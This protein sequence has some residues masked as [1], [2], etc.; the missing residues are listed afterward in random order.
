[1]DSKEGDSEQFSAADV[2][3]LVGLA[4]NTLQNWMRLYLEEELGAPRR[5]E[6][7]RAYSRR[8]VAVLQRMKQF[9]DQGMKPGPA[10][11]V[12]L[13][14]LMMGVLG[15]DLS[16]TRRLRDYAAGEDVHRM[17]GALASRDSLEERLQHLPLW[18]SI[19]LCAD[20]AARFQT[21]PDALDPLLG[22]DRISYRAVRALSEWLNIHAL[23]V[24][25]LFS[26]PDD[27]WARLSVERDFVGVGDPRDANF[28]KNAE[29]SVALNKLA[30]SDAAIGVLKLAGGG[31][32]DRH[33]HPGTEL[34]FGLSGHVR[35]QLDG[36]VPTEIGEGD[37]AFYRSE[38]LHVVENSSD[39]IPAQA[40]IIRFYDLEGT[41][42]DGT[43]AATALG[44]R[45]PGVNW[46]G[47]VRVLAMAS[48]SR[49]LSVEAAELERRA[50]GLSDSGLRSMLH[51]IADERGIERVIVESFLATPV[52]PC[53]VMPDLGAK[54]RRHRQH[55]F[56]PA[57]ECGLEEGVTYWRAE[58]ALEGSDVQIALIDLEAKS[59]TPVNTHPGSELLI[60]VRG[61]CQVHFAASGDSPASSAPASTGHCLH[62]RSDAPHWVEG[63][64]EGGRL[65]T[66]RFFS[67]R[68][69]LADHVSAA[70]ASSAD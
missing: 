67:E 62:Y 1:M 65:L 35:L 34:L 44:D 70:S 46:P 39:S 25:P 12:A 45:F 7:R 48:G 18:A 14:E 43:A 69:A 9:C 49:D 16:R 58:E 24:D 21:G 57:E 66:I 3:S 13:R 31:S 23:M 47:L 64:D 4:P 11:R 41:A 6:R 20:R 50:H 54:G 52:E 53:V 42:S 19:Y 17:V 2:S 63:G 68:W 8:H 26:H 61:S 29:Y 32:S 10:S 55:G 51:G 28:G 36:H 38:R 33:E 40:L 59:Q 5:G 30:R 27:E 56:Q 15:G 37:L 22:I 60:P